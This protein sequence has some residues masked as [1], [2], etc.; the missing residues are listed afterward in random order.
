MSTERLLQILEELNIDRKPIYSEEEVLAILGHVMELVPN[1]P[2]K[3][4]K[5][6]TKPDWQKR[7]KMLDFVLDPED[8][9]QDPPEE[10]FNFH[11]DKKE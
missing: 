9:N 7:E 8:E 2:P 5:K 1:M 4:N 6:I 10:D 3:L 11:L